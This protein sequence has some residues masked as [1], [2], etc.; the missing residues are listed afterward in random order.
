VLVE[1]DDAGDGEAGSMA[2][3]RDPQGGVFS[4]V[5]VGAG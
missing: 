4:V 2:T 3:L 1:P 5:E